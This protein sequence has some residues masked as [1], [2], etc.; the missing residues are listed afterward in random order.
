MKS[1]YDV[2]LVVEWNEVDRFF[3]ACI[4]AS[5]RGEAIASAKSLL[6]PLSYTSKVWAWMVARRRQYRCRSR[7]TGEI[8]SLAQPR[9]SIQREGYPLSLHPS[10]QRIIWG[11]LRNSA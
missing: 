9:E 10:S 11:G 3:R 7:P 1:W 4:M 6:L 8:L 5:S 2:E